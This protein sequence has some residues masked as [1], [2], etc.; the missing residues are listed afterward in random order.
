MHPDFTVYAYTVTLQPKYY[1]FMPKEQVELILNDLNSVSQY[2]D[3]DMRF[4]LTEKG[5]IHAHGV[6]QLKRIIYPGYSQMVQIK[7]MFRNRNKYKIGFVKVEDIHD[8][9]GWYTYC[10]KDE[11]IFHTQVP[12]NTIQHMYS[13]VMFTS[14]GEIVNSGLA[15]VRNSTVGE[16][17]GQP[18]ARSVQIKQT[19]NHKGNVK[20]KVKKPKKIRKV[21]KSKKEILNS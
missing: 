3:M 4:E 17:D 15:K 13:K 21:R 12:K 11:H 14:V 18:V 16:T 6:V 1:D 9:A 5:N 10:T 20:E 7:S 19:V 2:V 8:M